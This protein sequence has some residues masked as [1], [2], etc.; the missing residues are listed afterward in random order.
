MKDKKDQ[1]K[2]DRDFREWYKYTRELMECLI[3][4][5]ILITPVSAKLQSVSANDP[6]KIFISV[7]DATGSEETSANCVVDI[8]DSQNEVVA[9]NQPMFNDGGSMY[10]F[11]SRRD[12]KSGTY[13][14]SVECSNDD[15]TENAV[16]QFIV[17]PTVGI[18]YAKSSDEDKSKFWD[19][20]ADLLPFGLGGFM[21][22]LKTS[23]VAG[24]NIVYIIPEALNYILKG[25]IWTIKNL[26]IIGLL[27]EVYALSGAI[28][29]KNLQ[30]QVSTF[31]QKNIFAIN[32]IISVT[33]A[34]LNLGINIINGIVSTVTGLVP[35]IFG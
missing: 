22:S 21:S 28:T 18:I 9:N 5:C 23:F 32:F 2:K 25:F 33:G 35:I 19:S 16:F 20:V 12:W 27:F 17:S 31:V 8:R 1:A 14:A 26:F 29:Q 30:D 11:M 10:Y 15:G 6:M 7:S 3:I 24:L 13:S 34:I 4:I